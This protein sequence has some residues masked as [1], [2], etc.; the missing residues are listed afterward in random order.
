MHEMR[1]WKI[2]NCIRRR[3]FAGCAV[4]GEA[5]FQAYQKFLLFLIEKR[6]ERCCLKTWRAL[7]T[8]VT[9]GRHSRT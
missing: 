1:I 8:C 4:M 2:V 3:L 5:H 6:H 9:P 7:S